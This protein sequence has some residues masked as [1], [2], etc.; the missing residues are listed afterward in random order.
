MMNKL[1]EVNVIVAK[2]D[3]DRAPVLTTKKSHLREWLIRKLFGDARK[4]LILSSREAVKT[5]SIR[6]A[7][8]E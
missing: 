7:K 3:G 6:E 5:I 1:H 2:P 8:G 4:I